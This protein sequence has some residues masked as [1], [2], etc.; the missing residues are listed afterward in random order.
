MIRIQGQWNLVAWRRVAS[1][2]SEAFPFG[3]DTTG[4][5]VYTETGGMIV[6]MTAGGRPPLDTN[7][8]VGGEVSDRAAA[9]S[10]YLAYFGRYEVKGE[11][12]HHI[13]EG[14]SF[15]NWIGATQIRPFELQGEHLMLRTPPV[16]IDGVTVVN[17]M[18]WVR[19]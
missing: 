18:S 8:P 10:G 2:G 9:Y 17:E 5:L 15:P 1:D 13:I 14:S 11:D 19:R 4:M 3:K 7:D 6:Q 12:V 16:E